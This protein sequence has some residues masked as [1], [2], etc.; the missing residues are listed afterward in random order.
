MSTWVSFTRP[1]DW[2][3]AK[4]IIVA[5]IAA[6]SGEFVGQTRLYKAFYRAHVEYWRAQSRPMT[7]HR[8]VWM[9]HG[10]G[11]DQGESLIEE[12]V[13]EGLISRS[14]VCEPWSDKPSE[15]YALLQERPIQVAPEELE[16]IHRA[17]EWLAKLTATQASKKSHIDS[18]AWNLAN[19]ANLRGHP[20]SYEL[21]ALS[22][23]EYAR[24]DKAYESTKDQLA[25]LFPAD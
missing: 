24:L 3:D 25:G 13:E 4:R 12:L 6:A 22:D 5:I 15:R 7:R 17:F 9:P 23:E 1:P 11:I 18:R 2:D 14:T 20:L 10:P 8:V 19:D 16:A 21:D